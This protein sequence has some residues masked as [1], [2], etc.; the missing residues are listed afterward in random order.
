MKYLDDYNPSFCLTIST[1]IKRE[2]LLSIL[3]RVEELP[4]P[5]TF[6]SFAQENYQPGRTGLLN[7]FED[8]EFLVTLENSGFLGVSRQTV[9]RVAAITGVNHYAALC[10]SSGKIGFQ[11]VEIQDGMVLVNYA[12][13][14]D[15]I[16]EILTEFFYDHGSI[17]RGLIEAIEYRMET[18]VES[19][20]FEKPTET[21]AIDYRI[22]RY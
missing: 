22:D 6:D 10:S 15:E 20:W 9:N 14:L 3:G 4:V 7:V 13:G 21:Y 8:G 17:R 18:K 12:P 5:Q 16:P 2:D 1:G 11:Y 19:G